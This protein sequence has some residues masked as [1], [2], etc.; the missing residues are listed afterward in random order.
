[1][2]TSRPT[3]SRVTKA[4]LYLTLRVKDSHVTQTAHVD[5][6]A[7]SNVISLPVIKERLDQIKPIDSVLR[8]GT[9]VPVC[10]TITL[11]FVIGADVQSSA[12][13]TVIDGVHILILERPAAN[14]A[15][16]SPIH[17]E[18]HFIRDDK[19]VLVHG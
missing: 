15:V 8:S 5:D 13:F 6:G 18:V 9:R 2:K 3:L 10:G 12:D 16:S 7:G 11:D 14:R 19:E 4:A 17:Q 1:M